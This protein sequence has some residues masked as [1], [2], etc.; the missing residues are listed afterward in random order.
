V[1][2]KISGAVMSVKIK[3]NTVVVEGVAPLAGER[4]NLVGS[5]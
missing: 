3:D 5:F 2:F 1:A 4:E